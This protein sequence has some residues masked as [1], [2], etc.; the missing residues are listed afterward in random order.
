L[1]QNSVGSDI[2][3]SIKD[4][5]GQFNTQ[6]LYI[7]F[8][9]NCASLTNILIS[10]LA[11]QGIN[12]VQYLLVSSISWFI[13]LLNA[14]TLDKAAFIAF[15]FGASVTTDAKADGLEIVNQIPFNSCSFLV[16]YQLRA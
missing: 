2:I 13:V 15:I 7:S 4:R 6:R 14:G 8:A 5:S 10:L 11:F 9:C 1:P 12:S 16:K 3:A